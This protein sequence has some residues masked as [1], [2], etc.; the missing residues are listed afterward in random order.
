MVTLE[1]PRIS[2]RKLTRGAKL[3]CYTK[4]YDFHEGCK[5]QIFDMIDGDIVVK[6]SY[7]I[8]V[9]FDN[10]EDFKAVFKIII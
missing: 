2:T 1:K 6:D 4:S 7:G 3:Y 5:Y 9:I 8:Q 10:P